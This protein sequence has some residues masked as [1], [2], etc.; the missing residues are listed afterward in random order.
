MEI[1]RQGPHRGRLLRRAKETVRKR[2][3][4]T[5]YF[6]SRQND[7]FR[8]FGPALPL[9]QRHRLLS[10]NKRVQIITMM[11]DRPIPARLSKSLW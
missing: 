11:L 9:A 4:T 5:Y 3:Y 6:L 7:Y 1:V 2:T 8:P 10:V